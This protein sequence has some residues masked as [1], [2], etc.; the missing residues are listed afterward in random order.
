MQNNLFTSNFKV[1]VKRSIAIILL[2]LVAGGILCRYFR[3]TVYPRDSIYVLNNHMEENTIDVLC[4]GSSHIYCT[5]NPVQMYK[6]YGI[7][8]YDLTGGRQALWYSYFYI[9][10]A[11]KTQKPKI[12]ILDVYTARLD[13]G[14]FDAN[15]LQS[16]LLSMKPSIN[17]WRALE[18]AEAENK[19]DLFWRFPI[20]HSRYEF[21]TKKDFNLN[22]D[23][24]LLGYS[25]YTEIVPYKEIMDSTKVTGN[26]AIPEKS[27]R[28]LRKCI[29]LCKLNNI[30]VI[31]FNS[32][33]PCIDEKS[34]KQF[35]YIQKIAD[36]YKVP[37]LNGCL[38]EKIMG[39][40]YM[41]DSMGN[42]G[43]LNYTGAVKCTRWLCKYLKL[44]YNLEDR[45]G[46]AYYNEWERQSSILD[47]IIVWDELTNLD[48][49]EQ[50]MDHLLGDQNL[51]YII[52]LNGDFFR[53]NRKIINVLSSK[54]FNV[55]QDGIY[56]MHTDKEIFYS[57]GNK[58]YNYY[59]YF[60][61]SVLAV[62]GENGKHRMFFDNEE[63]SIVEDGINILVY[64]EIL[65]AVVDNVAFDTDIDYNWIRNEL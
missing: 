12:I 60:D 21:L 7:A 10:E 34:Q 31:L 16:N 61:D 29:E 56:V 62:Y 45:R 48:D 52:S 54:G 11:I 9:Q 51:Y 8:A 41:V 49:A 17:K 65:N 5:I 1:I 3:L 2:T 14:D 4:V 47:E 24:F 38:Y 44:H 26:E 46:N 18:V 59:Q 6:D 22:V 64:D 63:F 55:G 30:N 39:I 53:E 27:E 35:N 58:E 40:D 33:W 43:H 23:N 13:E 37:F 36:E 57:G 19:F 25:Y 50:Y 28:Y 20:T 42:G 32:P 15:V